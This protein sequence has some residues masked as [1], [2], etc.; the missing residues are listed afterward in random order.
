MSSGRPSAVT[1]RGKKY[2][3]AS[4]PRRY[5]GEKSQG[6]ARGLSAPRARAGLHG[7]GT[8]ARRPRGVPSNGGRSGRA[9]RVP[10]AD[11]VIARF[12]ERRGEGLHHLAFATADIREEMTRL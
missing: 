4:P 9:P 10:P 7:R 8:V 6:G 11:G 5:R 12:I 1:S 2:D 3:W